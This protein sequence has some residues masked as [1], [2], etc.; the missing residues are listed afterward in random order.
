MSNPL[1]GNWKLMKNE[2]F[3]EYM[4]AVGVGWVLRKAGAA[5]S[6]STRI[7]SEGLLLYVII[8]NIFLDGGVR[9]ATTSTVKSSNN[10]FKFSGV[11]NDETTLDGRQ[12]KV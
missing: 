5:A 7:S 12:V 11:Q 2:N 1:F 4:S 8:F 10:F 3:D 6:S 9:V